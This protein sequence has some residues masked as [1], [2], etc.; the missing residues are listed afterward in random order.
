MLSCLK[1]CQSLND[2]PFSF[3]PSKDFCEASNVVQSWSH[4]FDTFRNC[5]TRKTNTSNCRIFG[6]S[7]F[8]NNFL[9]MLYCHI[10]AQVNRGGSWVC[11]KDKWD[12]KHHYSRNL[13]HQ[14]NYQSFAVNL[15]SPALYFLFISAGVLLYFY[16]KKKKRGKYMILAVSCL[17]KP[18]MY[19]IVNNQ[20][21]Y[22]TWFKIRFVCRHWC[23]L[24]NC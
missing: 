2:F 17:E 10:Y 7:R 16:G 21:L 6:N 9:Q 19:N 24:D 13:E 4:S 18:S 12:Y 22:C 20:L 1:Q 11:T 23:L 15:F 8:W 14:P 3:L 5:L